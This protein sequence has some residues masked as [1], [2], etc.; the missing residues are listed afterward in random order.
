M[1]NHEQTD[2]SRLIA[3]L[4]NLVLELDMISQKSEDQNLKELNGFTQGR[5]IEILLN[6]GAEELNDN[7]IFDAARH[8]PV[9][10]KIISDEVKIK[11][12]ERTGLVYDGQVILKSKV[13]LDL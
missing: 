4:A 10:F 8:T 1:T 5:I 3:D 9:P 13:T 2:S 6:N 11:S 7:E 12:V